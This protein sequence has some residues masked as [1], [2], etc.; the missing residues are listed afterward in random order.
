MKAHETVNL[1]EELQALDTKRRL[2][3][4]KVRQQR[5]IARLEAEIGNASQEYQTRDDEEVSWRP[6]ANSEYTTRA[7]SAGSH[8]FRRHKK[9]SVCDDE[10]EE[11]ETGSKTKTSSEITKIKSEL[12]RLRNQIK[13]G[14][15]GTETL[16]ESPLSEEIE[17]YKL[18]KRQKIPSIGQFD[19]TTAP[20]DFISQFDGRMSYYGHSEIS[21]CRF[22]C[23]CLSGTALEWFENLPPRSIDSWSTLKNK[24]R[25]RFSSNKRGGK[26][27]ASLMTVRQKSS[28]SLRDFLARF[29]NEVAVIPNLIDELAINYLAAGV[30]KSRHGRIL[31]EFFEKNPKTLQAAME[32]FEHRLTIQEAVGSIQMASPQAKKWDKSSGS[33][34]RWEPRRLQGRVSHGTDKQ[35]PVQNASAPQQPQGAPAAQRSRASW[36]PRP[37]GKKRI[38]PN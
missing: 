34:N 23:T 28:E 8:S 20:S 22:F 35:D 14:S 13:T 21:R 4:A 2:L 38:S 32:I 11:E 25:T 33:S 29:R 24:F 26:I 19:G 17:N 3:A 9:K 6:S 37:P 30:D 31:E 15:G 18:D 16:S 1:E 10:E 36:P 12:A 27:T 7:D 5:E